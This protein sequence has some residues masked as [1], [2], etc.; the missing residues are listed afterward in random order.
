MS[1]IVFVFSILLLISCTKSGDFDQYQNIPSGVWNHKKPAVFK[2]EIKDTIYPKN[3]F[4]KIRHDNRYEYSNLF[5]LSTFTTPDNKTVKD[6]LEYEMADSFGKWLGD[7]F[8]DVNES[9]LYF[10][11]K[12]RFKKPGVYK[13]SF[14]QA[15]RERNK[16]EGIQ[17][18]P[19]VL[20]VGLK[21]ENYVNQ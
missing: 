3:V 21:I 17:D 13:F 18:L 12:Y 5:I 15:M 8:G 6:T 1:R 14:R 11:E 4:F 7:G 10:L 19:G 16:K 9:K 20:D 2:V